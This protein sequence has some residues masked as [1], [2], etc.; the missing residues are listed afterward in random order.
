MFELIALGVAGTAAVVGHLRSRKFVRKRLRYTSL[1]DIPLLGLWAGLGTVVV[2][3]PVVGI[4]PIVGA[5]T[6]LAAGVGVGSGVALGVSDTKKG[7]AP[8]G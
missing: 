7:V 3:A 5:G 4:L 6:A 1:V 8:E 2:A